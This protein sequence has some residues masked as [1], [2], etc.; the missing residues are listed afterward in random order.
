[1]E[2]E[3]KKGDSML[4]ASTRIICSYLKL[5]CALVG[6]YVAVLCRLMPAQLAV[7]HLCRLMIAEN[8]LFIKCIQ[9]MSSHPLIPKAMHPILQAYTNSTP[10]LD[11]DIDRGLL[12]YICETYRVAL[13]PSP[14][15]SG[16][17]AMA[18]FG[19]RGDDPV[20]VKVVKMG[21]EARIVDGCAHL[22][23]ASVLMRWFS[24]WSASAESVCDVID[25]VIESVDY[26]RRQ[27]DLT[28]EQCAIRS[29][30]DGWTAL[31]AQY[32]G[33][34]SVCNRS[35]RILVPRTWSDPD[36]PRASEFFIMQHVSGVPA[37]ALRSA[38]VKRRGIA[39]LQYFILAQGVLLDYYHTD[40]HSGNVLF[41]YDTGADVLTLGIYDF[42]MHVKMGACE[43]AFAANIIDAIMAS[44]IITTSA[45][46]VVRFC[47]LLF[48]VST[49]QRIEDT[50]N[51]RKRIRDLGEM[52]L[53]GAV[54]AEGLQ[55]CAKDI[56]RLV[57]IR[58]KL[59]QCAMQ[60]LLGTSM[61]N[62]I[63]Y[64][65]SDNDMNR[66]MESG[67]AVYEDMMLS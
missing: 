59:N 6:Y 30:H 43:R 16:M 44:S 4:L 22:Q 42:G 12:R 48:D 50:P 36:G 10:V 18:F 31:Q 17:V 65:L 26:L 53:H 38:D 54:N 2:F 9:A 62:S 52:L 67:I 20:V 56:A 11:C 21:V 19:T 7:T 40:M 25:T 66:L 23:F 8:I 39:L 33:T 1:M 37:F 35:N 60:M 46:D 34:S 3:K 49:D 51:L 47:R 27:C 63:T 13:E 64:E 5:T 55:V 58:P 57:G 45:F 61:V 14:R 28:H 41:D 24:K 32:E 15:H 29:V